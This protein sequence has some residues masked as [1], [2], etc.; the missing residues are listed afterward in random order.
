MFLKASKQGQEKVMKQGQAILAAYH[1]QK[2]K[3]LK[4]SNDSL[5][6]NVSP[7]PIAHKTAPVAHTTTSPAR[8]GAATASVAPT[9]TSP[10]SRGAV[11]APIAPTIASHPSRWTNPIAQVASSAGSATIVGNK[12]KKRGPTRMGMLKNR[13][14]PLEVGFNPLG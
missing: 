10:T 8:R 7:K 13:A 2:N 12:Q 6:P 3:R 11:A 1:Q 5:P 9:T 14:Q 4:N